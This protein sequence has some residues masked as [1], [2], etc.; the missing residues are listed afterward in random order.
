LVKAIADFGIFIDLGGVD[1][2]VHITDLS[3]GR[4]N[5]PS[6][7]VKLDQMIKVKVL[8]FDLEK[9]RI[10]LG[11]KQL[12]PHP[13]EDIEK[14]YSVGLKVAGKVVSLTDYGAFI[15][16]EKGIEGLIHIS[17]MSWTQHIKQPAQLLWA[18]SLKLLS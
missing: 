11:L 16:I 6:E 1:G 5:H 8:D 12:L 2:L 13:W 10:S 14:K 9:K 15:E 4:V 18:K 7:V 17:E 3:W